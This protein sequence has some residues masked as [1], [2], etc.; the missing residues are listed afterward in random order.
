M[1][2]KILLCILFVGVQSEVLTVHNYHMNI[3]V[4]RAINLMNSELMTRIVGGSQVTT[5]TSFPF[6]AGIIATLTTGFTS[7]CGGTLLSNT[8][9]LTAAHCW[10]DGQSQA[11][12]FTVVLGSLT[13]FSGGTRIETSR[14]VVHPN[15]NTNEITHDIAMVTIARV[16]FT[17]NIQSIPIPDLADINHNFA[18]ASA[19]VS[20]YGKTSDGQGSFPTTTSLHQTTV[21]VITNAVCQKSFDITLHGSHLCT[22]GQG[23]VGSCDGDSGGP[24]TTIRNNRRTVIGVVSFGLG[25]RCQ[26]GYP[27]VYTRVTAFLTW[28]QANL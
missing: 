5:P 6:Q 22:N 13:I 26:S 10:W 15:W 9:V 27:S 23:G 17:N 16:S 3:G 25:D 4:P 8:K 21:Q 14:I 24:L 18:G 20:G 19:V 28:I 12:L 11:R 7:I 2:S 1:A